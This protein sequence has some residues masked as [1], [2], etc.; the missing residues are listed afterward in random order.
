[1]PKKVRR[2]D[3]KHDNFHFH[4]RSE[5]RH[6]IKNRVAIAA[7]YCHLTPRTSEG[8]SDYCA[9]R[10]SQMRYTLRRGVSSTNVFH[11][12]SLGYSDKDVCGNSLIRSKY[13]QSD[14]YMF[15]NNFEGVRVLQVSDT[16]T[17][18]LT[19]S[20]CAVQYA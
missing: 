2:F 12:V 16:S 6:S 18:L 13:S 11:K 14:D 5:P 7:V 15:T 9:N 8:G 3:F 4:P 17:A 20:D 10:I 1:M 19:L